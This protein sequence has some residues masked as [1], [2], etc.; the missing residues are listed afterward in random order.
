MTA[1]AELNSSDAAA[2]ARVALQGKY[3]FDGCCYLQVKF[4]SPYEWASMATSTDIVS[5]TTRTACVMHE[6]VSHIEMLAADSSLPLPNAV[7][8]P[9]NN[10]SLVYRSTSTA[11]AGGS[12][13]GERASAVL[14]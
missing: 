11:S 2:R 7:D 3:L 9:S 13:C 1:I 8:V 4:A 6:S 12:L 14:L 5:S 10:L